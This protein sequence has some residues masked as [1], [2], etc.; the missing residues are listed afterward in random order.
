MVDRLYC[1]APGCRR[2]APAE[3]FPGCNEIVCPTHWRTVPQLLRAQYA[4]LRRHRRKIKHKVVKTGVPRQTQ[5]IDRLQSAN[6]QAIRDF[7]LS[8]E[9]PGGLDAFIRELGF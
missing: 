3:K 5:T 1:I 4:R 6:W 7:I 9:K 2:T 8:S